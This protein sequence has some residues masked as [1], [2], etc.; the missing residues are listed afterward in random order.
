M[1]R[2]DHEP[3]GVGSRR[4]ETPMRQFLVPLVALVGMATPAAAQNW[5]DTIFPEQ[6]HD[7][8]TVARGSKVKFSFRLVNTTGYDIHIADW[9]T[10]CGCTDVKVG[11]RD[12]PPG[13][14]TFV[15]AT[16][17]TTKF[18][19]FKASGLTLIFDRPGYAEK[20]LS[21]TCFIRGDVLVNPGV[22]DFG[23]VGRTSN[24][25]QTITLNYLGG[26]TNWGITKIRT[27][28]DHISARLE[29]VAGTRTPTS[30]Q[31]RLTTSLKPS[32]PMGYFTDEITLLTNDPAS[33]AIPVSVTANVQGAVVVTPG[34]LTLGA[35]KAGQVITRDVLVRSSS[36]F[37]VTEATAKS[38][39]LS[40]AKAPETPKTLHKITVTLKAPT[41]PGP[42][43]GLLEL[44]TNLK[45][46]P[47]A[48]LSTFATVVP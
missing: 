5:A 33:P 14:Q 45:D 15:E 11:A 3:T 9:R 20:D 19:G 36:P 30:V 8:G 32:A 46:E 7:F 4:E 35:V 47:P 44:K 26:Q 16:L 24:A 10:K 27:V 37:V 38:G 6:A 43:H 22:V 12:I 40:I 41:K 2:L 31:Y 17:D 39:E 18:Q 29:E 1:D 34:I 48:Q 28:S 25:S 23:V 21:L 13:T 42:F